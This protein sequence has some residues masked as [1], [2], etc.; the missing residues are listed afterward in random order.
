L[1]KALEI[2]IFQKLNTKAVV[3]MRNEVYAVFE[4]IG[5]E[6]CKKNRANMPQNLAHAPK[7]TVGAFLNFCIDNCAMT[8]V[9]AVGLIQWERVD[10][11]RFVR[12]GE[13]K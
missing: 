8:P 11:K 6:K 10:F 13:R 7:L 5:H 1:L 3:A 12:F 4:R 9:L 2:H